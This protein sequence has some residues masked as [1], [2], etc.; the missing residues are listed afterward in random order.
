MHVPLASYPAGRALRRPNRRACGHFA[1]SRGPMWGP[2]FFIATL[3][4]INLR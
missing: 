1:A 2:R 4:L 3:I